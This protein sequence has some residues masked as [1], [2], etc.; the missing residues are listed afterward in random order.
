MEAKG[1][2]VFLRTTTNDDD[3]R[4]DGLRMNLIFADSRNGNEDARNDELGINLMKA[5]MVMHERL[6][7]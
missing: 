6:G 7:A 2:R 5:G 4:D 3:A 1:I